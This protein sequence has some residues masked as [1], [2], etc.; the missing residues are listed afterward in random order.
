M[1][2][3]QK[4]D[5]R[6]EKHITSNR[7][8]ARHVQVQVTKNLYHLLSFLITLQ[9]YFK[10]FLA[11]RSRPRDAAGRSASIPGIIFATK[12]EDSVITSGEWEERDREGGSAQSYIT[13]MELRCGW[14]ISLSRQC[15]SLERLYSRYTRIPLSV[16]EL[17]IALR[18]TPVELLPH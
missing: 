10:R 15:P 9:W 2:I 4:S 11:P 1:W 12:R 14:T 3:F 5:K 18:I 16:I 13:T 8:M 17:R 7:R 6:N